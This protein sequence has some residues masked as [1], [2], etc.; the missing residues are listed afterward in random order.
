LGVFEEI[1]PHKRKTINRDAEGGFGKN[2]MQNLTEEE[3]KEQE[4]LTAAEVMDLESDDSALGQ[5]YTN[6]KPAARRQSF[7]MLSA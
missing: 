5:L 3:I 2:L 7:P 4:A 1:T 6:R